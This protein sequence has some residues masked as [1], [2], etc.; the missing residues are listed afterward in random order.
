MNARDTVVVGLDQSVASRAA[1]D[2]ALDEAETHGWTVEVVTAWLLSSTF[3]GL[4][5]AGTMAEGQDVVAGFQT[6]ALEEALT[7]RTPG[8]P[9]SRTVVHASAGRALVERSE[10]ARMLV[11]GCGRKGSVTRAVLGSVSEYCVRHAAA[12]VVVVPD[13][14]RV[15]EASS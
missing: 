1:L 2:F 12:P 9:V 14:A 5:S 6:T 4:E 15:H 8:P 3:P 11:V 7:A 10:D 13:P